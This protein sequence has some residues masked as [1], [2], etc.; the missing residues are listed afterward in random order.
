MFLEERGDGDGAGNILVASR[1]KKQVGARNYYSLLFDAAINFPSRRIDSAGRAETRERFTWA[2]RALV[3]TL[4]SLFPRTRNVLYQKSIKSFRYVGTR[5]WDTRTRE[6]T[7]A[8]AF[9]GFSNRN[10]SIS[11]VVEEYAS[12]WHDLSTVSSRSC[13]CV[14]VSFSP[15]TNYRRF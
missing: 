2:T 14:F 9:R 3:Q 5:T 12:P 11:H 6:S 4:F 8:S 13:L 7:H 1:P 10:A 15:L